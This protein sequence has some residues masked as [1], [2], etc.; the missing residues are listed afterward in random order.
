MSLLETYAPQVE[1]FV[2][3]CRRLAENNFVTA[4]GGNA[5]WKLGDDLILITPT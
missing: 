1:L 5:A 3:V 4:F 2:K